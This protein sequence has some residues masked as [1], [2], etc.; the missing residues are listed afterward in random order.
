MSKTF[1]LAKLTYY[2]CTEEQK[3]EYNGIPINYLIFDLHNCCD[4]LIG[5]GRFIS[6]RT[7]KTV[8]RLGYLDCIKVAHRM[9]CPWDPMRAAIAA[10][11]GQLSGLQYLHKNRCPWDVITTTFAV[12]SED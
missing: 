8:A 5:D 4:R 2:W 6:I 1:S 9:G 11:H 3:S 12:E 10:E 7:C